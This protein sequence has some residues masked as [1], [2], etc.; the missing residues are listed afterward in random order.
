MEAEVDHI[1]TEAG[2]GGADVASGETAARR[3]TRRR[4][5]RATHAALRAAGTRECGIARIRHNPHPAVQLDIETAF[6][7]RITFGARVTAADFLNPDGIGRGRAI[8][9]HDLAGKENRPRRQSAD[10]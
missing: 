4:T 8:L 6:R 10:G 2:E 9:H 1:R 3:A 5:A 7:I